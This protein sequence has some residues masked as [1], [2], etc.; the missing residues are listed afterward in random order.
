MEDC[1][2]Y[3][4]NNG[5]KMPKIGLGTY[6]MTP[7]TMEDTIFEA[8]TKHNV[9]SIDTASFYDNEESVG[10]AL[11]RIFKAGIKRE[12]VFVTTKLWMKDRNSA[13]HSLRESL[14]RLQLDYVDLFLIHWP[15]DGHRPS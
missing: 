4:L 5:L 1:T 13:E 11:Q 15:I 2:Y 3:T 8:F 6:A 9:R 10:R 14:K 7:E 12:E